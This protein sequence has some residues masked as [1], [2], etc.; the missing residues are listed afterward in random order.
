L[1]LGV[2]R[3]H[4]I[5]PQQN[6]TQE[7]LKRYSDKTQTKENKSSVSNFDKRENKRCGCCGKVGIAG[8]NGTGWC[9]IVYIIQ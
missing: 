9:Q 3:Y 6:F 2:L 5:T 1:N 8:E 7:N 4:Y